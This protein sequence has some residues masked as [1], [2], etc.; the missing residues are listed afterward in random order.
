MSTAAFLRRRFLTAVICLSLPS[1]AAGLGMDTPL[2]SADASYLGESGGDEAGYPVAGGG[3]VNVDGYDDF[4]IGAN[5]N[6]EGGSGA[7]QAYLILGQAGGWALG[8]SLGSADASFHGE[9]NN[10]H[11]GAGVS[12]AGDLNGD[13]HDDLLLPS[14][15]ANVDSAYDVGQLSL[16]WGE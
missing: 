11:A 16:F 1:A 9:S 4:L 6:D 13:G 8:T 3:D 2:S 14:A 7:G 5:E 12:L 10:D 15:Y